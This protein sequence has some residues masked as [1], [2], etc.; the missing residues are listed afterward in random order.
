MAFG[1]ITASECVCNYLNDYFNKMSF[2][3]AT[4]QSAEQ[5]FNIS[6]GI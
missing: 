1:N 5:T 2:L 6:Y 3:E 4:S